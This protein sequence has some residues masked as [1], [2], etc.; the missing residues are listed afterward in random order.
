MTE[1]QSRNNVEFEG[2]LETALPFYK[3]TQDLKAKIIINIDYENS[4]IK[5]EEISQIK[6]D[7]D[8]GITKERAIELMQ[9]LYHNPEKLNFEKPFIERLKENLNL[10]EREFLE[11]GKDFLIDISFGTILFQIVSNKMLESN[12][13]KK[14]GFGLHL[15]FDESFETTKDELTKFRNLTYLKEFSYHELD[16]IPTYQIDLG[17]EKKQVI[18][19]VNKIILDVYV[20]EKDL[21]LVELESFEI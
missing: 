11:K 4:V 3:R 17:K 7:Q 16:G 20:F 12:K 1:L 2:K 5:V 15:S 19:M 14:G 6:A 10:V 18:E 8:E 13:Y 9:M 21:E